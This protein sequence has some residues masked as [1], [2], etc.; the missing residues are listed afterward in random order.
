MKKTCS[1]YSRLH[2]PQQGASLFLLCWAAYAAAYVGRY[3]YSALMGTMT[4]EGVLTLQAAGAIST[5]YFCVI[6]SG[7]CSAD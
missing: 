2:T 4:T 5:G 7:G 6:P 3:N 1:V